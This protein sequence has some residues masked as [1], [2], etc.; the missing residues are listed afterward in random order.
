MA[1]FVTAPDRR[2]RKEG[3]L[4]VENVPSSKDCRSSS[5]A[6]GTRQS[7]ARKSKECSKCKGQIHQTRG[8]DYCTK[9]ANTNSAARGWRFDFIAASVLPAARSFLELYAGCGVQG[10]SRI[11]TMPSY[12]TASREAV[13]KH[14]SL[15][16]YPSRL[17]NCTN[18]HPRHHRLMERRSLQGRQCRKGAKGQNTLQEVRSLILG[19]YRTPRYRVSA[20]TLA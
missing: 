6:R 14:F 1:V 9:N 16:P 12:Q 15:A 18:R 5:N 10:F 20:V 11:E 17:P 2:G 7:K 19:S 4:Q 13:I 3:E 8:S